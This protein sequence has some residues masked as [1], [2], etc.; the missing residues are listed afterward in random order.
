MSTVIRA[1]LSHKSKYHIDKHVRQVMWRLRMKPLKRERWET[2]FDR[3][4]L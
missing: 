3:K 4:T 1:E 2:V